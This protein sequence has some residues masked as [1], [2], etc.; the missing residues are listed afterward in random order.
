MT[1]PAPEDPLA[2]LRDEIRH[3]G[4]VTARLRLGAVASLSGLACLWAY[5]EYAVSKTAWH[6][7]YTVFGASGPVW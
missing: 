4:S 2:V 7:A 5:T 1:H 3:C 6:V